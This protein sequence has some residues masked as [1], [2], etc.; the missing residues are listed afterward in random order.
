MF[1]TTAGLHKLLLLS[2]SRCSSLYFHGCKEHNAKECWKRSKSSS[3][4]ITP[5]GITFH[6]DTHKLVRRLQENGFSEEQAE[7]LTMSLVEIITSSVLDVTGSTVSKIDQERLEVKFQGIVDSVR[8]EMFLL[9]KGKF[10]QI[11]EENQKLRDEVKSLKGVLQDEVAKLR[12]GM[13]LDFSLEKSRIKEELAMRDQRIKDTENRI[14]TEVAKL[15]TQLEAQKLDLIK[16]LVGSLLSCL[17]LF[18]AVWRF[19]KA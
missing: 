3:S 9:E 19:V 2:T 4:Y 7:G 5:G 12:G 17:T 18:L 15:G 11:Q 14:E 16:Y 6:F 10:T 1:S 13:A 8:N